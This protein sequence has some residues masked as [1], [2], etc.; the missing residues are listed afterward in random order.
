MLSR[1]VNSPFAPLSF[2]QALQVQCHGRS[3]S[4]A[5]CLF[6]QSMHQCIWKDGTLERAFGIATWIF[7]GLHKVSDKV[8]WKGC[9]FCVGVVFLRNDV[10]GKENN[11]SFPK[12]IG[13][14]LFNMTMLNVQWMLQG[15]WFS[16]QGKKYDWKVSI[17]GMLRKLASRRTHSSPNIM[18]DFVA[19]LHFI[20][21]WILRL[22]HMFGIF[23][24]QPRMAW[25]L[26]KLHV[27]NQLDLDW[28][29]VRFHLPRVHM[30]IE[31]YLNQLYMYFYFYIIIH[32]VFVVSP[33]R[34]NVIAILTCQFYCS[35]FFLY[36][37]SKI[38]FFRK[39]QGAN[40]PDID[41][42][43]WGFV[44]CNEIKWKPIPWVA[45]D[46]TIFPGKYTPFGC[47]VPKPTLKLTKQV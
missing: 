21:W 27:G 35:E 13:F 33:A 24:S 16:L 4:T 15:W 31:I 26:W 6:V 20:P 23:S 38:S 45:W 32:H 29:E 5:Q 7:Y 46:P 30:T 17:L 18:K 36:S 25:C 47:G 43:D 41:P 39:F 1:R 3:H 11:G 40:Q 8:D 14:R 34:A 19:L 2:Q 28:W 22:Y 44:L 42:S 37:H 10:N 9:L 12:R